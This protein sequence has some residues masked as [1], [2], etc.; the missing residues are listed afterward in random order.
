MDKSELQRLK[1]ELEARAQKELDAKL[2]E[3]NTY[4]ME[5]TRARE[6]LDRVRDAN[7]TELRKEFESMKRELLVSR[8]YLL[9]GYYDYY[10]SLVTGRSFQLN[11]GQTVPPCGP[12]ISF[13]PNRTSGLSGTGFLKAAC[14]SCH[15]PSDVK[16]LHGTQSTNNTQ[17]PGVIRSSSTT[18]I[19]NE[20]GV[21]FFMLLYFHN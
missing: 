10:T 1:A 6:R 21:S 20:R 3:V 15:E 17:W 7:E 14:S 11:L 13:V 12:L 18:K 19:S 2:E 4:L 5:Q 9:V 8:R 16:T